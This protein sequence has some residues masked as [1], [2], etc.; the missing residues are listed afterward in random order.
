MGQKL[1]IIDDDKNDVLITKSILSKIGPGITIEVASSGEEGLA[2]LREETVLPALILLDVK[3]PG[4]SGI[5]VLRKIR[6]EKQLN[7]I[8]VV[9]VTHSIIE[10]DL[11]ASYKSG[12]NSILLKT[13]DTDQFRRSIINLIERFIEK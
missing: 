7:P 2:R 13:V 10:D 9:I 1:L 12:A 11:V 5:D 3:M 4:M 8:P 6:D